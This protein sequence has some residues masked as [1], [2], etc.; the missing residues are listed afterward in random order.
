MLNTL[1]TGYYSEKLRQYVLIS[2]N[3]FLAKK[4]VHHFTGKVIFV[5]G[6]LHKMLTGRVS[7]RKICSL[8]PMIP[9]NLFIVL[10]FIGHRSVHGFTEIVPFTLRAPPP[11]PDDSRGFLLIMGSAWRL[12]SCVRGHS[13]HTSPAHQ[14]WGYPTAESPWCHSCCNEKCRFSKWKGEVNVICCFS[15]EDKG[16]VS[17]RRK[18]WGSRFLFYFCLLWWMSSDDLMDDGSRGC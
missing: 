11:P 5:P 13:A 4:E 15:A 16:L 17:Q 6:N 7:L 2:K 8:P 10:V 14:Q 1:K 9:E 18:K 3:K 12:F